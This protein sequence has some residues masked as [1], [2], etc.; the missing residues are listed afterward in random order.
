MS[1]MSHDQ[2]KK[3]KNHVHDQEELGTTT[4]T[5]HTTW[6]SKTHS[7][8]CW[9]VF[10][11]CKFLLHIFLVKLCFVFFGLG[12]FWLLRELYLLGLDMVYHSMYF[13]VMCCMCCDNDGCRFQHMN[14]CITFGLPTK[15][16]K[17]WHMLML[18]A[19]KC[20]RG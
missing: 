18:H 8:Y 9:S 11:L 4:K 17:S 10:M 1:A 13:Y 20:G 14:E 16:F 6:N 19:L 2:E 5:C 12:S 3:T 7:F 15:C